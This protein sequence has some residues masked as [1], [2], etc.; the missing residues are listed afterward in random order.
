VTFDAPVEQ[1]PKSPLTY[2]DPSGRPLAPVLRPAPIDGP[3]VKLRLAQPAAAGLGAEATVVRDKAGRGWALNNQGRVHVLM[4]AHCMGKIETIYA[5]I[6]EG[7]LG[8]RVTTQPVQVVD[9]FPGRNRAGR[10]RPELPAPAV[11]PNG[12]PELDIR[13]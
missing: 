1:D 10:G 6:F 2:R 12:R 8:E 7:I 13:K 5:S 3:D 4:A 11:P 9:P